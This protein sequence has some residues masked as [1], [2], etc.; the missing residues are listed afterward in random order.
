MDEW[1]APKSNTRIILSLISFVAAFVFMAWFFKCVP[2]S[3]SNKFTMW[4]G[5]VATA[6]LFFLGFYVGFNIKKKKVIGGFSAFLIWS[7]GLL[8]LPVPEGYTEAV[9]GSW[10]ILFMAIIAL[11]AKHQESKKRKSKP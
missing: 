7:L 4:L 5:A 10:A 8:F 6:F 11:H 2:F 3:P 1:Y 9:Y